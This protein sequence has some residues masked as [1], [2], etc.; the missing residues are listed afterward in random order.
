VIDLHTHVLPGV[1]DGCRTLEQSLDLARAAVEDGIRAIAATP[2][3]RSDF[4]TSPETMERLVDEVREAVA[5][6]GLPLDV[7]RGGE[8]ALDRL[9]L[10][11][12][13]E[14]RRFGL[15]GN[16]DVVRD[17]HTPAFRRAGMVAALRAVGDDRLARW[18]SEDVP[19]ALIAGKRLPDRP[20]A[21]AGPRRGFFRR[22]L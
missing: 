18:L 1:D 11:S 22:R 14:V 7:L 5:A 17:A 2:H 13:D 15:G 4:P 8:L 9:E 12:L 6:E 16:P 3:V 20:A 21:S 19:R 10:L